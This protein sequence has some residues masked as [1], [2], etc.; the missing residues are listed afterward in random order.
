M[1]FIPQ[2]VPV[3]IYWTLQVWGM[4]STCKDSSTVAVMF[5]VVMLL[6]RC[7]SEHLA[8]CNRQISYYSWVWESWILNSG[9]ARFFLAPGVSSHDGCPLTETMKFKKN[10]NLWIYIY[11]ARLFKICWVH[12]CLFAVHIF[13]LLPVL[14][15]L[16]LYCRVVIPFPPPS[17]Y[18]HYLK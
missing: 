4:K 10:R 16:G 5:C 8:S 7:H 13:I 18:T 17:I 11:L 15:P 6:D 9:I 1:S 3:N 14:L 2:S 12:F